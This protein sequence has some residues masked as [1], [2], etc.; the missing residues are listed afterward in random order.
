MGS[1]KHG[2]DVGLEVFCWFRTCDSGLK[3]WNSRVYN[4]IIADGRQC[5]TNAIT[6]SRSVN[7]FRVRQVDYCLGGS[8]HCS[9][10]VSQTD[11]QR[12]MFC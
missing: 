7:R 10:S 2:I 1:E 9:G 11:R 3:D 12:A 5:G 4:L 8:E 6:D